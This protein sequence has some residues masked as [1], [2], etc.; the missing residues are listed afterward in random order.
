[1][2]KIIELNDKNAGDFMGMLRD[3]ELVIYEDIQGSKIWVNWDHKNNVYIRPKTL[4]NYP[5]NLIDLAMQKVYNK[6]YLYLS[7]FEQSILDMIPTNFYFCF[8]YFYDVQPANIKYEK[9]PENNLILT[10]IYDS[11]TKKYNYDL[12][13]LNEYSK[14]LNVEKFPVIFRGYLS[15]KQLEIINTY[16]HTSEKD[17]DFVFDDCNFAN[18]FYKILNPSISNSF[19]MNTG[20]YQDN[21]EKIIIRLENKDEMSFKILNPFYT[22]ISG[23]YDTSFTDVYSILLVNFIQFLST[24]NINLVI[25]EGTT[26]NEIYLDYM[27]KLYNMYMQQMSDDLDK[28]HISIPNFF[29]HEKFKINTDKI[30]N[31]VTLTWLGKNPKFEYVFKILLASFREPKIK[32]VGIFTERTLEVFNDY[33]KRFWSHIDDSLINAKELDKYNNQFVSF[34]NFI[35]KYIETDAT[36][37]QYLPNKDKSDEPDN[38]DKKGKKNTKLKK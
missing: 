37:T 35:K 27:C 11:K 17:L 34:D 10:C 15:S 8:E 29:N 6:A 25:I 2:S 19:L 12:D 20:E 21:I 33:V 9:I 14:F 13:L 23:L 32:P 38:F 26:S 24:I 7:T 3:N 30:N 1:M 18:F 16:I 22:K 31:K 4:D 28:M 5:I 36:D